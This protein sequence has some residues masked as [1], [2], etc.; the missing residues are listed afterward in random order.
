MDW[1]PPAYLNGLLAG[2][3]PRNLPWQHRLCYG[4]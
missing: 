3:L 4:V 2:F 1:N